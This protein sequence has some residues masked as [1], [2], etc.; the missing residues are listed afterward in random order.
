MEEQLQACRKREG[1]ASGAGAGKSRHSQD[2]EQLQTVCDQLHAEMVQKGQERD[3]EAAAVLQRQWREQ[4]Q[5]LQDR[6]SE[7]VEGNLSQELESLERRCE[8]LGAELQGKVAEQ[9][10]MAAQ[11]LKDELVITREKRQRLAHRRLEHERGAAS[12]SE[13]L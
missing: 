9:D 10:Y 11:R 4:K 3:F 1:E 7:A 12:A 8:Q 5:K 13:L 2:V 6:A